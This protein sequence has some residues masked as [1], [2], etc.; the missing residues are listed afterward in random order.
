MNQITL[1]FYHCVIKG[2]LTLSRNTLQEYI[3]NCLLI[4]KKSSTVYLP[5]FHEGAFFFIGDAHAVQRDGEIAG[6]APE[7]S[8]DVA[9][10]IQLIKSN[11]LT[12]NFPGRR[13]F[14]YDGIWCGKRN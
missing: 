7:T 9:F 8:M 1:S 14:I 3:Y 4:S 2:D 10:T 12:I 11:Q 6:N 13:L 5:V